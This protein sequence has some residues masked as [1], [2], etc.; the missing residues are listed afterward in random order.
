[1]TGTRRIGRSL[2][3]RLD[4]LEARAAAQAQDPH[5]VAG[6][7]PAFNEL[8]NAIMSAEGGDGAVVKFAE[9]LARSMRAGTVGATHPELQATVQAAQRASVA[10][11]V[12]DFAVE[13][14]EAF[15]RI[16]SVL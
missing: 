13:Y 11:G 8:C 15:V 16:V 9:G 6:R 14:V 7:A 2:E 1:M 5:D 4:V 10:A 12:P 3:A